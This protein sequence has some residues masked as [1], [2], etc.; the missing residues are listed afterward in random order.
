MAALA[1]VA[2]RVLLAARLPGHG[3]DMWCFQDWGRLLA[4]GDWLQFYDRA[5]S[6]DHLPGD[7]VL[8]GLLASAWAGAGGVIPS[9]GYGV[10]IK[11]VAILGDLGVAAAGGALVARRRGPRAGWWTSVVLLGIPLPILVSSWWGQWDAGSLA[12]VLAA[13]LLLDTPRRSTLAAGVALLAW[14]MLIKPPLALVVL[15]LVVWR[16]ARGGLPRSLARLVGCGLVGALTVSLLGVFFGVGL[17]AVGT[18][19]SVLDR[20]SS[21]AGEFDATTLGAVNVWMWLASPNGSD[22]QLLLGV[23]VRAWGLAGVALWCAVSGVLAVRAR[24]WLQGVTL[25]LALGAS[26]LAGWHLLATRCHER[27]VVPA[28]VLAVVV[29]ALDGR[30]VAWGAA[31]GLVAGGSTAVWLGLT[32]VVTGPDELALN[33]ALAILVLVATDAALAALQPAPSRECLAG[34]AQARGSRSPSPPSATTDLLTRELHEHP[35]HTLRPRPHEPAPAH[36]R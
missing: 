29:A 30:R 22:A 14:A 11:M 25:P 21:A 32:A 6:G 35:S 19:W 17:V 15:P 24:V 1:L 31:A 12:L 34:E 36:R 18:R 27:Y 3:F 4:R 2:L 10:A 26:C 28:A 5:R 33:R 9:W 20:L 13:A 8:H 7:L 23:P 16:C